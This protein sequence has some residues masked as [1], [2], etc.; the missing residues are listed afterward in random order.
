MRPCRLLPWLWL[1]LL[2]ALAAC[3]PSVKDNT[4]AVPPCTGCT[5]LNLTQVSGV[6]LTPLTPTSVQL[7]WTNPG[8][9]TLT[10]V[11]I[12]R[13]TTGYVVDASKGDPACGGL[14]TPSSTLCNDTGLSSGSSYYYSLLAY[15]ASGNSYAW[16]KFVFRATPWSFI[17]SGHSGLHSLAIRGGSQSWGWGYNNFGQVGDNTT[18]SWS[19][20]VRVCDSAACSGQQ[21]GMTA[22][23]NGGEF[24]LALATDGTVWS[25]GNN[26]GVGSLGDGTLLTR[27]APV[28]VCA[29]GT[30]SG[31]TSYLGNILSIAAGFRHSLA[32][33]STGNVWSWG[34]NDAFQLGDNTGSNHTVP[35]AVCGPTP[36][37]SGPALGG[38]TAVAAGD[39]HSLALGSS[40]TV[41]AWGDET[42]GQLGNGESLS[43]ISQTTPVLVCGAAEAT[44]CT[45]GLGGIVAIA[46]GGLFSVALDNTGTVWTWGRNEAGQLGDGTLNPRSK[47]DKVCAAGQLSPCGLFLSNIVAIRAGYNYAMALD[48]SGSVWA[49]GNNTYGQL[50]NGTLTDSKVPV[51]VCAP[52][53]SAPCG[54]FLSN[55]AS[56][57]GGRYHSLAVLGDGTL[58]GWGDNENGEVGDNSGITR[59]I[60]VQ[61]P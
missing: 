14:V 43:G 18:T 50:G 46:A 61:V 15:Y 29:P 9:S 10:G 23:S 8:D 5:D 3:A 48:T 51:Q 27:K 52:S 34:L 17:A 16:P 58:W 13:S 37:C 55:A 28:H 30:L 38:I 57:G 2:P 39:S 53:T 12:R 47:P 60:P 49:W 59:A 6:S 31:C 32:L 19:G 11:M 41:Y 26:A 25:W 22:L 21:A 24:S 56:I 1:A 33:D 54:T 45:V 4:T 35:V 20:P 36:N 42:Y 44:P 7:A 40:G